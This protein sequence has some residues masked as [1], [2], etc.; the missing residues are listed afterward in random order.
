MHGGLAVDGFCSIQP[1]EREIIVD[2]TRNKHACA[3]KAD[4]GGLLVKILSWFGSPE[5]GQT[6]VMALYEAILTGA[7]CVL[8]TEVM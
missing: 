3:R 2:T 4:G 7:L 6:E 5:I 1:Y 8:Q